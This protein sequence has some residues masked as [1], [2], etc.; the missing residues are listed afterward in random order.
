M[1]FLYEYFLKPILSNGWF[2]P[3]N[4]I[5]YGIILVIGVYLVFKLLKKMNI[6]IDRYFL[7]AI[8]PFILWGSS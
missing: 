6:H 3:V 2:N 8:L 4:S 5:T 7:Y 1:D